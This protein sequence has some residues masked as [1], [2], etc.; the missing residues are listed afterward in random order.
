MSA[1]KNIFQLYVYFLIYFDHL[2]CPIF[3]LI[4]DQEANPF[5]MSAKKCLKRKR[6]KNDT[7]KQPG[8]KNTYYCI[9]HNKPQPYI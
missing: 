6:Y 7:K 8:M 9:I 4:S 3:Q 1:K 5:I 2:Y